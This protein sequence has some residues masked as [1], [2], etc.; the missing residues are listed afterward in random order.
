MKYILNVIIVSGFI[1]CLTANPS[2]AG[3]IEIKDGGMLEI[4]G[5]S[6][7]MKCYSVTVMEGA[8]LVLTGGKIN[9]LCHQ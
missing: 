2:Q 4:N 1:L 9:N 7:D 5:G 3:G 8:A 6:L